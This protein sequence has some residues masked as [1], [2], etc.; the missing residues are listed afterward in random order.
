MIVLKAALKCCLIASNEEVIML[1]GNESAN[2]IRRVQS[3]HAAFCLISVV[4]HFLS[5]GN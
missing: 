2:G 1:C 5:V 3:V 4:Y